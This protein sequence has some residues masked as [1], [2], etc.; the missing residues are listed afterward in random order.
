MTDTEYLHW[1]DDPAGWAAGTDGV[2]YLIRQHHSL[3]R[4]Y[5]TSRDAADHQ[6]GPDS[7]TVTEAKALCE[8]HYVTK[9]LVR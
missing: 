1:H 6:I 7:A 9:H 8:T 2:K 4:A 5:E 3:Y